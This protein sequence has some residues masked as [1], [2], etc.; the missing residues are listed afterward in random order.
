MLPSINISKANGEFVSGLLRYF[1]YENC[2]LNPLPIGNKNVISN[3]SLVI[4]T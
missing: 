2:I 3:Y 4:S 1:L